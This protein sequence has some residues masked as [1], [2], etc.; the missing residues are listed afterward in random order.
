MRRLVEPDPYVPGHGDLR[1]AVEHYDL[2]LTYSPAS[3]LL[4]GQATLRLRTQEPT[5]QVRLDLH[6]LAVRGVKVTGASLGKYSHR[7]DHLIINLRDEVKAGKQ[8]TVEVTYS[9]NPTPVRSLRLG[10][11]G[12]E[13]LTDGV[14]VA[15]QPHGAPS[16]FPCN[17]RAADKATYAA[18]VSAPAAYTVA[19][20]GE[21]VGVRRRGANRIWTF[22]QAAP[23]APYLASLQ[24]GQYT[25]L[26]LVGGPA[27]GPPITVLHPGR[28]D[29]DAF[30]ATF[31]R[32]V[33]MMS[34]FEDMFGPYPM[35]SYQAV[36]TDDELEIPL[37]SQALSTFGRNHCVAQWE[38]ERLVAHEMAHQWF[39]NAVTAAT[40]RDIW[41]HEG[42]AC[43][44]EWLWSERSGRR[45]ADEWAREYH[46]RLADLG[47]R[48]VLGD[49]GP[50]EMFDDRVYKRGALTLHAI[51]S[52]IGDE[53]FFEVLAAW[54]A[55][56]RGGVAT[57]AQWCEHV[58]RVSGIDV[59][60]L[61]DAWVYRAALPALPAPRAA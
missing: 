22:R 55:E 33:E 54:V 9:G 19:F 37:E 40:W 51:R 59:G 58:A 41:L 28:L 16:W 43:Y 12:W 7:R 20:S 38:A 3:N 17:D 49:P 13:E 26:T 30:Q 47:Q 14:I 42:F 2:D 15:S 1:Y 8:L 10:E 57:T 27:G 60:E 11:A 25:E 46:G 31:G 36:I 21:T 52:A 50:S 61:V 48:L 45:S 4:R 56:N 35:A 53:A 29:C 18:T 44:A 24:I 23:M 32:Q 39:G 34:A 6:H 5:A